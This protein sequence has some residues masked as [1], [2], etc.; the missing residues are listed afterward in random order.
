[1][2][3]TKKQRREIYLKAHKGLEDLGNRSAMAFCCNVLG[4]QVNIQCLQMDHIADLLPEFYLFK[5]D[6]IVYS[7][8]TWFDGRDNHSD[9]LNALLLCAELTKD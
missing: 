6:H 1:M 5:P 2:K 3:F 4:Q 8:S 9:R 7:H